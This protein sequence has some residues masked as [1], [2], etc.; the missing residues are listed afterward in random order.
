MT[1]PKV[2]ENMQ[3]LIAYIQKLIDSKHAYVSGGDVYFD[4]ASI[5]DYGCLSKQNIEQLKTGVRKEL[6]KNKKNEF[7]FAL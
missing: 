7:D 3:D 1:M 2:S 5:K 4:V 6:S